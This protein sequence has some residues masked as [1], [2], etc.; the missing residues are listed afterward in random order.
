MTG[1]AEPSTRN[2]KL[3]A[4]FAVPVLGWL[5]G[6]SE[7]QQQKATETSRAPEVI[8]DTTLAY[9]FH[10][11]CY[12][13]YCERTLEEVWMPARAY[14]KLAVADGLLV[15]MISQ[16]KCSAPNYQRRP[17]TDDLS[18]SAGRAKWALER[19]LGIK[20]RGT[21]T[22]STTEGEVTALHAEA[23]QV[24]EAYRQGIIAANADRPVSSR[25]FGLLRTKYNGKIVPESHEAAKDS[26]TLM[27]ELLREWPPI[28]KSYEELVGIIGVRGQPRD[29]GIVYRFQG[30]VWPGYQ[31]IFVVENGT[32]RLVH[33]VLN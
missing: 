17:G 28:G 13:K 16:E 3:V 7:G 33:R 5:L 29:D 14:E 23:S 11:V 15:S 1:T 22:R 30:D 6:C 20:L 21:V 32:I 12:V 25:R 4:L 19:L 18:L 31:F 9:R 27:D 10:S 24:V 26:C 8:V 2:R